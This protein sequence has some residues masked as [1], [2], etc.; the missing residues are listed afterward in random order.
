M[1]ARE[2]GRRTFG[3]DLEGIG[4]NV[5]LR[6]ELYSDVSERGGNEERR[7]E[8][9][10]L[11]VHHLDMNVLDRPLVEPAGLDVSE[12]RTRPGSEERHTV[13]SYQAKTL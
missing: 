4:G 7:G 8:N 9:A 1:D 5:G 2:P 11:G 13:M 3:R 12:D 10:Y 6:D